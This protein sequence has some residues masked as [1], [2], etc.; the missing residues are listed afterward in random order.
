MGECDGTSATVATKTLGS[1]RIVE[2]H[3]KI[4]LIILFD[5]YESIRSNTE[6]T[7]AKSYY[8]LLVLRK[9]IGSVVD[10]NEVITSALVFKK[11]N[12]HSTKIRKE[13]T[14]YPI[15]S[16]LLAQKLGLL[17]AISLFCHF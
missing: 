17:T 11:G 3:V 10:D 13:M 16:S 15:L 14:L 5:Q 12:L 6:F 4:A 7:I 8:L 9:N 1:I 2:I